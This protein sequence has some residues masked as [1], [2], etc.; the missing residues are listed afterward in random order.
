MPQHSVDLKNVLIMDKPNT[1]PHNTSELAQALKYTQ[2]D[3]REKSFGCK[4]IQL[5]IFELSSYR[6]F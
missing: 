2:P 4:V 5:D 1:E 6:Q 3:T